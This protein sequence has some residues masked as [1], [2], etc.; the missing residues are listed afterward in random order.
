MIIINVL[1]TVAPE[2]REDFLVFVENLVN[3]SRQDEG[4]L[5]YDCL[6]SLDTKNR[7]MIIEN[8]RDQAAVDKHNQTD[9]LIN[10]LNEIDQYIIG[11]KVVQKV[12]Y[13]A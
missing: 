11:E 4:A 2:K 9:H 1:L 5:F 8:W 6:E 13:P 12:A 3:K 7:F 10:F